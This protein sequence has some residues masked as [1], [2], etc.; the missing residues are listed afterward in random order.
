[1]RVG[2]HGTKEI[3]RGKRRKGEK[4]VEYLDACG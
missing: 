1:V 4:G 2:G 3:A